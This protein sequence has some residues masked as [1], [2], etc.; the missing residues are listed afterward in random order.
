LP[1][2]YSRTAGPAEHF[3][4]TFNLHSVVPSPPCRR[5]YQCRV[6][7]FFREF[8]KFPSS[9]LSFLLSDFFPFPLPSVADRDAILSFSLPLRISQKLVRDSSTSPRSATSF[10][11][12]PI[13]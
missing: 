5:A 8:L 4:Q 3:L 13:S 12:M 11:L 7:P 6:H 2:R 1:W 10:F 9:A